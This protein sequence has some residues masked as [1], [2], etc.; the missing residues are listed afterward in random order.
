M[1]TLDT[2]TPGRDSSLD[3]IM[4]MVHDPELEGRFPN[5]AAFVSSDSPH[6]SAFV[7]EAAGER[8]PV[9][10]AFPGGGYMIVE[11]KD[12]ADTLVGELHLA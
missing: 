3:L 12:S 1:G 5:R 8:R 9:V 4:A 2:D 7:I 11:G 10:V 6:F